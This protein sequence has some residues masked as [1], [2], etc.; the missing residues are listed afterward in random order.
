MK[1]VIEAHQPFVLLELQE[2]HGALCYICFVYSESSSHLSVIKCKERILQ[3][4]IHIT[5]PLVLN[6]QHSHLVEKAAAA[7]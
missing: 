6:A 3:E 7:I 5:P 4:S 1:T 2:L